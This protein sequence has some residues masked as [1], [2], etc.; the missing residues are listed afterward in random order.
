MLKNRWAVWIDIEGFGAL[1]GQESRIL[2]ALCDLMEGIFRI[3]STRY[4][5]SPDR[6]FAHQTGDGFVLVSKFG[7]ESLEVPVALSIALMQHVTRRGRFAKASIGEGDFAD[8]MS[9]YPECVLDARLPDSPK[10]VAM[11]RSLM[12]L[13]LV[14]GTALIDAVGVA[15][16]S[17][18]GALFVMDAANRSRLPEGCEPS[19]AKSGTLSIDWIHTQVPLVGQLQAT[20]GLWAPSVVCLENLLREYC[21]QPEIPREWSES[22]MEFLRLDAAL[23]G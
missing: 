8:I 11:G 3:C 21:A 20:A 23:D 7:S 22:T 14:M 18:K 13:F 17:S 6:I 5:E 19:D 10:T 15:K 12:T 2:L 9:C 4:H 16:R 1:Y